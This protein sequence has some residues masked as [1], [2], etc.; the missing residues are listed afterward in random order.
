[1][2]YLAITATLLVVLTT[3]LPHAT[4]AAQTQSKG[5]QDAPARTDRVDLNTADQEALEALPGVGPR[6][7]EL[8]IAYR[9]E[10]GGFKKVE[11]LM[12]IRGIGER[13]FLRL[14]KLVQIPTPAEGKRE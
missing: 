7:A 1:M 4:V 13:T 9:E 2:R 5:G 11:E 10:H 14:R 8:I 6:T 12:N 3:G